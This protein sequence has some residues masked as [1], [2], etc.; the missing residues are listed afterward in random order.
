MKRDAHLENPVPTI[1]S[2]TD[3]SRSG[4]ESVEVPTDH[5]TLPPDRSLYNR[6]RLAT[7]GEAST[8]YKKLLLRLGLIETPAITPL[9]HE[10]SSND[11]AFREARENSRDTSPEFF[12]GEDLPGGRRVLDVNKGGMGRV[13]I[14]VQK[15]P[16]ESYRAIKQPLIQSGKK[17]EKVR[18]HFRD[19]VAK[20]IQMSESPNDKHSNIVQAIQYDAEQQLL[21]LE[22]VHGLPISQLMSD[23][24]VVHPHHAT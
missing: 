8:G 19:E 2:P 16:T 7:E 12:A 1:S 21:F 17:G 18:Q 22:Y 6:K 23:E 3:P 4:P 5:T 15:E 14:S 11:A 13:Y 10:S 24:V 9:P 20:W